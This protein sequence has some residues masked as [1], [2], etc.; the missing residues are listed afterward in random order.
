M[1]QKRT[2]INKLLISVRPQYAEKILAGEKTVE[3]RR[4]FPVTASG[5]N[6]LLYSSSPV[7][8]VVGAATIKRVTKIRVTQIWKNHGDEACIS[9]KDFDEY[10]FDLD[11]GFVL[12]LRDV[13]PFG[14]H[15]TSSLLHD[16]YGI[17]PPQ[18]YRYLN[19]EYSRLLKDGRVQISNRHKRR[20]R[21]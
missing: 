2:A 6:A 7:S 18:S 10:F 15:L 3:L 1:S 19:G 8:A 9:R 13:Q 4:R 17:V 14:C 5:M 20:N 21:T 12:S 11:F 16:M